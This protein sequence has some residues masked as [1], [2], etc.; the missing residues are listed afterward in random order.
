MQHRKLAF[1]VTLVAL[2]GCPRPPT[3]NPPPPDLDPLTSVETPTA[4]VAEPISKNPPALSTEVGVCDEDRAKYEGACDNPG[5]RCYFPG[6]EDACGL[7]G[8]ECEDDGQ[9]DRMMKY[10]NPPRP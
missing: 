1:I 2:P 8:Y 3:Q 9:W 7:Q 5:Y 4:E 6:K 10:C